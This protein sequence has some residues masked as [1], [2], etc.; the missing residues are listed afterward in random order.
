MRK[1]EYLSVLKDLKYLLL[2]IGVILIFF[3]LIFTLLFGLI[4]YQE[5]SMSPA[6]KDGDLVIFYR[7]SSGGYMLQDTVVLEHE[8]Q[9]QIRRVVANEGDTVD[10]S[11]GGLVVNGSRQHEPEIYQ[12]TERY[13][14]GISF[15][16]MVPEGEIFVLADKRIGATDSRIYG[17]V[18]IEDTYGKVTSLL[19]RR[20]F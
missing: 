13:E 16:L 20:S 11:D 9:K 14:E 12:K 4:R 10:I 18:K 6:I 17:C 19:R 7:Y 2:K 15:P 3:V 8:G 1:Q 5:P